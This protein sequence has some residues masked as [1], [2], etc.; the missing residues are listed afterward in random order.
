V[1]TLRNKP[2]LLISA[3]SMEELRRF[4]AAGADAIN[5]GGNEYGMR[6]PGDMSLAEIAECTKM[7]HELGVKLYVSVN[8]ILENSQL[9]ELPRY[10]KK[11][12]DM[13]VDA[14]VF[15]DPAVLMS[16]NEQHIRIPLHWNTEMTS[17]NYATA[18]YWGSRGATRVILARELNLE[19]IHNV[20]QNSDLEVQVQVH[21]ITNIYHSK[22]RL[23]QS[24]MKH[25]G[26]SIH[27]NST[28]KDND[29]YLVEHERRELK[30]PI[31]EDVNGTHIMSA[32]DICMIENLDELLEEPLDSLKIETLLKSVEYNEAVIRSY[33]EAID[34]FYADA[35]AYEFKK[36]WLENIEKLQDEDRELS[37]GFFFKEQV[38]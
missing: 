35:K 19:E 32:D 37:Y 28:G 25:L 10:L 18:N 8:N 26:R 29:L 4:A 17:T 11:L 5:M 9:D 14:I 6:M 22:R 12:E 33:R 16:L 24:Y 36:H 1:T 34:S 15:G 13:K 30:L 21:G 27:M 7:A 20:K 2:E 23:V 31:Y 3:G 38:Y